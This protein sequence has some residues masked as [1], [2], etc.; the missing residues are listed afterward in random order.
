MAFESIV[1]LA[2]NAGQRALAGDR[3][4]VARGDKENIVHLS[5]NGGD[6]GIL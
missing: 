6:L 4:V 2:P 5:P 1:D 3:R